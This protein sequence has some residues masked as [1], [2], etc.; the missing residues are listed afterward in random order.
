MKDADR[1]LAAVAANQHGVFSRAQ[2]YARGL[3]RWAVSR[4]VRSG[5]WAPVGT[6]S[7]RFAGADV[8][9]RM[10]LGAGLLDLGDGAVVSGRAAAALHGLDGATPGT[11]E[12]YVDR[13]RRSRRTTGVVRS[14]PELASVDRCRV[15]GLAC[16]T[17]T[18]AVIQLAVDGTRPEVAAALDS[19]VRLGLTTPAAVQR[20]LAAVR[21]PGRPGLAVL[22]DVLA[23]AGVQSWLERRFVRVVRAAGL[24]VPAVQRVYRRDGR[25]VARVDFDFAPLPV[26]VEVGGQKGYLTRGERQ[27]QERRRTELQLLGKTVYFFAYEDVT[28]DVPY[29]LRT[30]RAAL[31][32]A[33]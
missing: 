4:R 1:L 13:A 24:P 7:F 3:D 26:I 17:A 19:A 25:H 8:T 22:D 16:V 20:R 15:D 11:L 23:D 9:W 31:G 29:V 14:G 12:F 18:A 10:L 32:R 33:S 21:A 5:R 30:L 28:A 27:R 6:H 2:A